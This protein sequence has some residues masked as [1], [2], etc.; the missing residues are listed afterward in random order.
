MFPRMLCLVCF[1]TLV[2][3]GP[4]TASAR[5]RIRI[6]LPMIYGSGAELTDLGELPAEVSEGLK[7]TLGSNLRLGFLNQRF[8][9]FTVTAW[10][11]NGRYVI[12]RGDQH[13]EV[14]DPWWEAWKPS[15]FHPAGQ[16]GQPWLYRFPPIPILVVLGAIWCLVRNGY[17]PASAEQPVAG[18]TEPRYQRAL[19][20]MLGPPSDR[21]DA[22]PATRLDERQL[23][24]AVECLVR[25][26]V[27][28]ESA[29]ANLRDLAQQH[30]AGLNDQIDAMLQRAVQLAVEGEYDR[31]ATIYGQAIAN[32][33]ADD[34]RLELAQL[35]LVAVSTD[36][37]G[38]RENAMQSMTIQPRPALGC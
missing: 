9:L 10:T 36:S 18:S 2:G 25:E 31:S 24:L 27:P 8:H 33:P 6:P 34:E 37:T 1:L 4:Q 16:Y 12:Y 32:L 30:F 22:P 28:A 7:P 21:A 38:Y 26:G 5:T 17:F 15:G 29:E 23:Q 11:W 35:M 20:I 13:W 3:G 19:A 14:E